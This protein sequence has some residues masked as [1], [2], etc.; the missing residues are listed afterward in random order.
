[1]STRDLRARF[2]GDSSGL[3]GTFQE[4]AAGATTADVAFAKTDVS[5]TRVGATFRTTSKTFKGV[6]KVLRNSGI[7]ALSAGSAFASVIPQAAGLSAGLGVVT[8]GADALIT[9]ASSLG[10]FALPVM[11]AAAIAAGA[12]YILLHDDVETATAALQAQTEANR[13][14]AA[15]HGRTA[16]AVQDQREA[17]HDLASQALSVKGAQRQLEDA[18]RRVA[19]A[20]K[21]AGR[22][23]REYR[24]AVLDQQR[25]QQAL[26]STRR[27]LVRGAQ[28][29]IRAT[30]ET[31]REIAAETKKT[32]E[33]ADAARLR[34]R[35]LGTLITGRD[36]AAASR[37]IQ[38][39][40]D[41]ESNSARLSAS[42][43]RENAATLRGMADALRGDAS[44]AAKTMRD[45]LLAL[46]RQEVNLSQPRGQIRG[47]GTDSLTAAGQVGILGAALGRIPRRINI[48][49]GVSGSVPGSHGPVNAQR[50]KNAAEKGQ[51]ELMGRSRRGITPLRGEAT[52]LSFTD[53]AGSI[54]DARHR[55]DSLEDKVTGS[56]ARSRARGEGVVNPDKLDAI[57]ERAVLEVRKKELDADAAT[58]KRQRAKLLQ[59]VVALRKR[60]AGQRAS[61]RKAKKDD[62][63]DW[64]SKIQDTRSKITG[65][66]DQFRAMGR[67]LH[68]IQA[69]AKE[70]GYDIGRLDDDIAGMP[71]AVPDDEGGPASGGGAAGSAGDGPPTERDFLE[72]AAA[73]AS[74]TAGTDDDIAAAGGLVGLAQRELDAAR[75]SGDPRRVTAAIETLRQAQANLDAMKQ[76]TDALNANTAAVNQFGG[77]SVFAYQGQDWVL[78]S[79]APPSSDRLGELAI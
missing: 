62:Q 59:R 65:L 2:I 16:A 50:A 74:L 53:V 15:Q 21:N 67:D 32:K 5:A 26:G 54:I 75:A 58:V 7:D 12:A 71:N 68:E 57:S 55:D 30:K 69:D 43:H 73:E 11:G 19:E 44:P 42:R 3:Q 60:L 72:A 9:T 79:L 24:D 61:R 1:M 41:A 45:R 6:G 49:I 8:T 4:V 78:R 29:Q 37:Q 51:Q 31:S 23:S 77:S 46:A 27:E 13:E 64:D 40:L 22:G 76:N 33:N 66:W 48:S 34:Q 56:R 25:A 14:A 20:E 47:V 38:K 35:F 36:A 17:M 18:T 10:S 70:I 52:P 39:A 28:E 63:P